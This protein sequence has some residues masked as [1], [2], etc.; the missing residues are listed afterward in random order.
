MPQMRAAFSKPERMDMTDY[1]H[2]INLPQTEFP[3][4][5][6]LA[7]R[8]PD[9]VRGWEERGVYAKL[10][11][12]ARGRPRFVL[13]DGPPYANG[14]IHIGHAVNKILKDIVVK[15]R[16]LDGYDSPYIPGWDCHGL[17]IEHQVEKKHGRPGQKLDAQAFRA[18]CRVYAQQQL[19]LQ[20]VDFKRLGVLGDWDHPYV[21]MDPRY[22]AQQLRAF[23]RIIEN[24]HLYK[25]VKPVHWCIDCRSALAEAEV[26]YEE[27]TS[28]AIDVAFR[29]ADLTD[30]AARLKLGPS[31]L[32]AAP[33]DLVIWTTTPWTLPANQAVA[34]RAEFRYVLAAVQRGEERWRLILAAELLDTC[35]KRYGMT[36]TV[37]A[38]AEGRDLEGL[39]VRHPLQERVVPV[40]L[41]E[42]VT[43]EAGTGAVHTAPGHGQEDFVVG[44]RYGLAVVNPVDNDGRFLPGT[45]LVAGLRVDEANTVLIA[46]LAAAGRLVHQEQVRHSYPHCWR[47]KTPVIFR[48]TPQWFISMEQ[49]G[50]RAHTLRD[51]KGV[52]W[53]PAWGESRI[54]GMI[55][56]RPDWCISRQRTWGV[57]I[58]LFVHKHSGEL[59]PR[60]LELIEEV[61]AR[62]ERAGIDAWFAL[63]PQELL[64]AQAGE[65][66]KATDV[67]DVWADSGLSFECVGSAR[68]EV[69]APVDLYLEGSDQHRGWFHSSL[70]MSE[71]LYER[72]P[73]RAVLT[74][75][76][77]VDEK[78][79]KQSKSL[80]N[81]IAPQKVM[82]SLGADVLRLWVSATDYANEM[83]VSD[84][85]LRRMADSYRRMRNTLRFLLGNLH[86]FKP[87]RD[88]LPVAELLALDQWALGRA[89][90][91]QA[92]VLES[93]RNY[94]F[95]LIY[96][97]VH[98]F[99]SVDMGGFY[100]DVLKDRL[101]TTPARGRPRRSAQTAMYHI[102]ESMVRWLAPILSFTAEEAWGYLP[103]ER[104]E[105]VFH[106]TWYAA[107]EAPATGIDWDGLMRL[108]S[109]V[110]RELERLRDTGAI[111][112]PLDARVDVYCS[113][114]AYPRFASLGAELRFLLI[115][116]EAQVHE[117]G[118]PSQD[119]VPATNSGS[120][121]VWLAV[122]P[123]TDAKC[124]RCWHR[125]PDVGS[126]ARHPQLCRRCV[127]NLGASRGAEGL[128]MSDGHGTP[129][130]GR[131]ERLALPA[132]VTRGDRGRS[133]GEGLGGA[134]F[135]VV[136]AYPGTARARADPHLQPGSGFQFPLGR[137]GLAALA[138]RGAGARGERGADCL[139]AAPQRRAARAARLR[140]RVHRRRRARQYDRPPAARRG[141][142]LRVRALGTALLSG[143]QRRRFRHYG[144][145]RAAAAGCLARSTRGQICGR[146]MQVLLANPRGFCAGVD[147]AIDI[148]ER[149]IELFGPPIYVR[150]EV[151]HNRYVV[152]RLRAL[153]AVFVD[154]LAEVAR[155]GHRD[156]FRA[157]RL[158]RRGRRGLRAAAHGVQRHLPAGDQ[159]AHGG[160]AL[161]ARGTRRGPHRTRGPPRGRGHD[162]TLRW[163][164]RRPHSPGGASCR[165]RG[166]RRAQSRNPRARHPDDALG[167]RHRGDRRRAAR[168]LPRARHPAPRGHLLR[169]AESPGRGQE[170][171]RAVR[172]A[173]GRGLAR[174]LQLE[175]PARARRPRRRARI[176]R[177]RA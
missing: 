9:M 96:Q 37:I 64:G 77:T 114:Q 51:I 43:L 80:G 55:E 130:S 45:E 89:R 122:R 149:A 3:M 60:T 125:R 91:L 56:S 17:P 72:A 5:A 162:G 112:A 119:A 135:R 115:T 23:G 132:A 82:N 152:E 14:A 47:H 124:V 145:R 148:V 94:G 103:G 173:A 139:A 93:Y 40:V 50:L 87:Q 127:S 113:A 146:L 66:D 108:R 18:A 90:A 75:G 83:S 71:A 34:L 117:G 8:E 129:V 163:F 160:T 12:V 151:V 150:H 104:R 109:D 105:S 116:S 19:D 175:P 6:N 169:H 10:R 121:G 42:H 79:R 171:P 120:A 81:V 161:R 167:G 126:D 137:F 165:R 65:Y 110:T 16:T 68:P 36:G 22:E 123:S 69:A 142:R 172:R 76:F 59:H 44:Q 140:A 7:Q 32:G 31:E 4:K 168:A 52:E 84:E 88:L 26:E 39:K 174:Q 73:Y 13:H 102:L 144:R 20:R 164:L 28:P 143:L 54:T 86:D 158:E 136:P 53:T 57:P 147:R 27:K 101:Y 58:P 156:L 141:G 111:G 38:S 21:T 128:R 46:A 70:L 78:G 176:S 1:K 24:G 95:H 25:G 33:V 11:E 2:T 153:G 85:I 48:A 74:H 157:R 177:R 15:S 154:E 107:P 155:R 97:K 98:N 134:P 131:S 170:A 67:M 92:E 49:A 138:V 41:G 159:G 61:A 133:G 118:E 62:V 99:C 30:L 166:A 106:E 29:V 100:L 63:A 35:L